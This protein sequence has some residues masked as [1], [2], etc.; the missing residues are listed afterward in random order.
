VSPLVY[1]IKTGLDIHSITNRSFMGLYDNPDTLK[2]N[3]GFKLL[4]SGS[5]A[6]GLELLRSAALNGHPN[7][8]ATIIWH[9]L[10]DGEIKLA[11][12]DYEQ[13]IVKS[14]DWVAKEKSRI[15]KIWLASAGDKKN[16]INHY[17]YQISNSKSNA[18]LA[19]LAAG[20]DE[21]AVDLWNEAA[22]NH[23]HI[24]ARFYPIFNLCKSNP[25]AAIGVLKNS[26]TKAELQDLI[27]T[28]VEVSDEGKGWF[29]QW[30]KDGLDILKK[31]SQGKGAGV[32]G[33]A[34]TAAASSVG[35]LAAKNVNNFVKNQMEES[36]DE[37]GEASDW[38]ENLF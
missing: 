12:E 26:F 21:V 24:E 23:G 30:A 8:L 37:G 18:G 31:V 38:F 16:L 2:N 25:T 22:E 11:I 4:E 10:L 29:A 13:C 28:C 1:L 14:E 20:K 6:Q 7:A 34:T 32:R 9:Y 3:E 17:N 15:D 27:E 36:S 33:T 35:F 5:Q 19:Y